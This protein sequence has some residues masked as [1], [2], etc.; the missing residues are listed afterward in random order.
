MKLTN[1]TNFPDV[2]APW[3]PPV[4]FL[5]SPAWWSFKGE[6]SIGWSSLHHRHSWFQWLPCW[7]VLQSLCCI[8]AAFDHVHFLQTPS[9]L[10]LHRAILSFLDFLLLTGNLSSLSCHCLCRFFLFWQT[11]KTFM[12][13]SLSLL[14]FLL[15]L[16]FLTK[17]Q[18][19]EH[20]R[21]S[22]S[23]TLHYP[24]SVL[25]KL[26]SSP[27]ALHAIYVLMTF[28]IISPLL[29]S[30]NSNVCLADIF[31]LAK[32]EL[33]IFYLNLSFLSMPQLSKWHYFWLIHWS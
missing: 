32:I 14:L 17:L 19:L 1:K 10:G 21:L 12:A 30:L 16:P 4:A 31:K 23:S 33:G 24:H 13:Q 6:W 8:P 2:T 18:K 29:T 9:S 26:S 28:Q 15:V 11:F 5:C 27:M 20:P 22:P 25:R 3:L 7:Q